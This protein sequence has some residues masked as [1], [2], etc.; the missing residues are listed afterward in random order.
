MAWGMKRKLDGQFDFG[1]ADV[2][3]ANDEVNFASHC[4]VVGLE[5]RVGEGH[6]MLQH[7]LLSGDLNPFGVE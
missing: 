1:F 2:R 3:C 4:E 5:Q 7:L 6:A